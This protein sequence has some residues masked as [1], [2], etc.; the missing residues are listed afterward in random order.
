MYLIL[1]LIIDTKV[2]TM[3]AYVCILHYIRVFSLNFLYLFDTDE[4]LL[5]IFYL[6]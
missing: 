1:T 3:I 5:L 4:K 6:F 2:F